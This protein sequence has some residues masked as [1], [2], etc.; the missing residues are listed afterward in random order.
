ML[1]VRNACL[2]YPRCTFHKPRVGQQT[3]DYLI[4]YASVSSPT[5]NPGNEG[6]VPQGLRGARKCI[7]RRE[8]ELSAPRKPGHK[9]TSEVLRIALFTT[10]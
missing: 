6:R 3:L 1:L 9:H 8:G 4:H 7:E 5:N 2:Q 10:H